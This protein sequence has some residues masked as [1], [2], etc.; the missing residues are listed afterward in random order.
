MLLIIKTPLN[1]HTLL[2]ISKHKLK[3][4]KRYYNVFTNIDMMGNYTFFINKVIF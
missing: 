3:R 2:E 4:L 1:Y